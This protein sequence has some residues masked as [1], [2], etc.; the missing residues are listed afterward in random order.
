MS[1]IASKETKFSVFEGPPWRLVRH[2]PQGTNWHPSSDY[3]KG[4]DE[5]GDPNSN[6]QPF[7]VKF[8]QDD[9]DQVP[10]F[11]HSNKQC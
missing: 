5:Y 1:L 10:S 2:V 7:S 3:L 9:F 11:L 8:D 4:T 6:D